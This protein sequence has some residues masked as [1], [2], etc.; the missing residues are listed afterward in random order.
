MI[1]LLVLNVSM[2]DEAPKVRCGRLGAGFARGF[3][4]SS[5]RRSSVEQ[6]VL[7]G[8]RFENTVRFEATAIE[9]AVLY[10]KSLSSLCCIVISFWHWI[11][12]FS[13]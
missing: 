8:T 1:A 4:H 7:V 5:E 12:P 10:Q 3:R 6:G 11:A 2:C 9:E 13:K